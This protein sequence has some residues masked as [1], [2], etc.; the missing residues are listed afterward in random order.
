M[1]QVELAIVGAGPAGCAAA[2]QATRL[3]VRPLL[4]DREGR[5]GGL[6]TNARELENYPGLEGPI[7]GPTF[8][9]RLGAQLERFGLAIEK[10]QV[11]SLEREGQGAGTRL[12]LRGD[13]GAIAARAAI[14]AAGTEARRLVVPG[15]DAL[16]GTRLFYEVK[17]LLPSPPAEVLVVGGGEASLDYALSLA[18]AGARVTICLRS[19]TPAARGRLVEQARRAP[20]IAFAALTQLVRLE[21]APAGVRA[22]L[23]TAAEVKERDFGAVVVAV[24]RSSA[25]AALLARVEPGRGLYLAGDARRGALGQA[26]MA[27]G[28]GLEAA[29]LAVGHLVGE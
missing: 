6:L 24:G 22:W 29:M 1:R 25:A 17:H 20:G 5:A 7:S 2:V 3:G 14:V 16:A 13:F 28:D 27:V 21:P 18:G 19:A 10:A 15:E 9:A 4:L 8:A 23:R 26:G 12:V 11:A